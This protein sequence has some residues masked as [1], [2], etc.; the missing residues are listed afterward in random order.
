MTTADQEVRKGPPLALHPQN[1]VIGTD[2]IQGLVWPLPQSEIIIMRDQLIG[3]LTQ[4]VGGAGP[5]IDEDRTILGLCLIFLVPE[6]VYAYQTTA[7][8]NRA[9]I[10]EETGYGGVGLLDRQGKDYSA[11][12]RLFAPAMRPAAWRTPFR[13]IRALFKQNAVRQPPLSRIDMKRDIVAVNI[14]G[15]LDLMAAHVPERV[16]YCPLW[17]WFADADWKRDESISQSLQKDV[18]DIVEQAFATGGETLP[19]NSRNSLRDL[20]RELTRHFSLLL[21]HARNS[22]D[23]LPHN[24]WMTSAGNPHARILAKAVHEIGGTVTGFDHGTSS[25]IVDLAT[26][27]LIEFGTVDT[28]VTFSEAMAKGLAENIKWDWLMSAT[29]CHFDVL[30]TNNNKAASQGN[31]QAQAREKNS[32]LRVM[33]VSTRYNG[34]HLHWMP[35]L[36]PD[37]VMIDWQARLFASLQRMDVDVLHKPHPSNPF[38]IPAVFDELFDIERFQAP[39]EEVIGSADVLLFDYP[40][41]T[42]FRNAVATDMPIVLID[43]GIVR[44]RPEARA[45]LERRCRIVSSHY[46]KDGRV[47]LDWREL[48][49][50]IAEAKAYRDPGY[51]TAYYEHLI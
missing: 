4:L 7:L 51:A 10:L 28:F 36:M 31:G 25:G 22:P 8:N 48:S 45:M 24:L 11:V 14:G 19:G 32:P 42:A 27:S 39:F 17:Y 29:P 37:P 21:E 3:D 49:K 2:G 38:P 20:L 15:G 40:M 41:S 12:R 23:R 16:V 9:D 33:Y 1:M 5:S 26:Q 46:D 35:L 13:R 34:A 43:V 47:Q 44:F 18:L 50:A 30:P 6:I